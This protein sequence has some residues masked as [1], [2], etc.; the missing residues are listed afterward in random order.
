MLSVEHSQLKEDEHI[1]LRILQDAFKA[2]ADPLGSLGLGATKP[3]DNR[4]AWAWSYAI[5]VLAENF[6]KLP[7][8]LAIRGAED[9]A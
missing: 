2:M 6:S 4:T 7:G 9:M 1:A 5:R 3:K 8:T